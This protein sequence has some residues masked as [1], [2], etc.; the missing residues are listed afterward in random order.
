MGAITYLG[1]DEN[2]L[3]LD[4]TVL[5]GTGHTLTALRLVTVIA[6]TIELPVTVLDGLVD[7][8]GSL[9]GVEL[10]GSHTDD[11]HLLAGGVE[12]H[13]RDWHLCHRV[14]EI[15]S[16]G[17]HKRFACCWSTDKRVSPFISYSLS[18]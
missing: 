17:S 8:I 11:G 16:S 7:G 14:D 9:L 4:E 13:V 2:V 15:S 3:T 10:P 1:G 6:G 12:G 18:E 5:Q